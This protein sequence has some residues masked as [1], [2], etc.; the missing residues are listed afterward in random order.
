MAT[1][2]LEERVS[3]LEHE[4]ARLKDSLAREV[5]AGVVWWDRVHGSFAGDSEF[6][7]AVRLGREHRL[8]QRYQPA[9]PPEG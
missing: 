9:E 4:V 7:E 3:V 6:D 2:Q 5:S 1:N 8:S